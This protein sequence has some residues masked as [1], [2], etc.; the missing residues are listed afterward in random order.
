MRRLVTAFVFALAAL[1]IV[2][3]VA[4]LSIQPADSDTFEWGAAVV[5][6]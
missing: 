5:T 6:N 3:G 4:S 1:A 2:T